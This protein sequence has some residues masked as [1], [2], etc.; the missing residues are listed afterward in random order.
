M[1]RCPWSGAKAKSGEIGRLSAARGRQARR[2]G[3]RRTLAGM[4]TSVATITTA[5]AALCLACVPRGVST[6]MA[7][8]PDPANAEGLGP[9]ITWWRAEDRR[10]PWRTAVVR[11]DLGQQALMLRAVHARDSLTGRETTSSLARRAGAGQDTARV[12]V[13][14]NADFFDLRT[15]R[16]ENNQVSAGEWWV[17]RMLTDSPFDTYDNVH[18]QFAFTHD[19][20]GSI[21]RYVPDARVWARGGALPVLGINHMPAGIYEGTALYTPRH[22]HR[23]PA[24]APADSTR[25]LAEVP[26]RAAGARGD[27]LLYVVS[28]PSSSTGGASIPADGAVFT[29]HG[30]RVAAVQAWQPGDT[31]RAWFGTSPRLPDGRPPRELI[32]GWPRILEAGVNVAA[33]APIREGT[34]SR[35]AEARH[36]RSAIGVSRD[37]RTVWLFAVDGRGTGS[38]GMTLVELADA[39]RALGAWDALNFDGGGSTTLVIDGR[40]VNMPT[41]ATGERAVGNALLVLQRSLPRR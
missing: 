22:G 33:D 26:L 3:R 40:V 38:V 16:S 32:G 23:T 9:G 39:M 4:R 27:T 2:P 8:P 36:P 35:N 11:L 25:R 20:R 41:D 7:A 28:A 10:G 12:R 19:G 29:A 37:G 14:I 13:A 6:T 15:G 31:V 34:I 17:G 5:A 18:A 21:G 24:R 1:H 30:D